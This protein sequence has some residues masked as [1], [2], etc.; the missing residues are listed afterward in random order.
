MSWPASNNPSN[1][2]IKRYG[3]INQTTGTPL[4]YT[5][6]EG[7]YVTPGSFGSGAAQLENASLV[8]DNNNSAVV[9]RKE[10][11]L[12]DL[13]LKLTLNLAGDAPFADGTGE[14]RITSKP[15]SV[16]VP[17]LRQPQGQNLPPVNLSLYQPLFQQVEVLQSNGNP[18]TPAFPISS[19]GVGQ[20][21]ARFLHGGDIALIIVDY[22]LANNAVGHT[23]PLLA[24]DINALYPLVNE[25][26]SI[27]ISI[28]GRYLCD[29]P[30]PH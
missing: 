23:V 9:I 14:V 13:D 28:K 12:V 11:R 21:M 22:N 24:S 20:L 8:Q 2:G 18:I 29:S 6:L 16:P 30:T 7:S 4:L 10:G 26:T 27:T 17:P 5:V 19:D 1:F 3:D 25:Q 15:A